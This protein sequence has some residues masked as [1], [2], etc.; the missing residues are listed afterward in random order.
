MDPT[1]DRVMYK[2]VVYAQNEKGKG[3]QTVLNI[4][5]PNNIGMTRK[6]LGWNMNLSMPWV[7]GDEIC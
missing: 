4:D 7:E 3:P 5:H 1:T 2:V 6:L